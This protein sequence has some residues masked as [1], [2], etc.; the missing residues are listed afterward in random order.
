MQDFGGGHQAPD[1]DHDHEEVQQKR[2]IKERDG[3]CRLVDSYDG[4]I[5]V[6]DQKPT[7]ELGNYLG[8]GVAGVVYEGHRLRPMDEYPVRGGVLNETPLMIPP[9][10]KVT[11]KTSSFLCGDATAILDSEEPEKP[12][13]LTPPPKRA[14]SMA[15][16][17]FAIETA[18]G[19]KRDEHVIVVDQVDAPSRSMYAAR[20]ASIAGLTD[21]TV[22]IKIL[23]PVGFRIVPV[24]QIKT[25][26]VVRKGEALSKDIIQR[27][28]PMQEKHVWWLINPSSRNL[29]TLQKSSADKF[30][31]GTR[32]RGLRLS[33]VAAYVDP[34]TNNL[35]E[36][37]LT[38]CIEIWGHVPF[39]ASDQEFEDM[40]MAIERI[41]AG[42][43]ASPTCI[44]SGPPSRV[45]TDMSNTSA[46]E[47]TSPGSAPPL[48]PQRTYV[49]H[50][51][52][53]H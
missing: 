16:A 36:L 12:L 25:A 41:N 14:S 46:E 34:T 20:A 28:H 3:F 2:K 9:P 19:G 21:E 51:D 13:S 32:E 48:T 43:P 49:G 50:I 30:E 39:S 23:N 5:I 11:A 1:D 18:V 24:E 10:Q 44:G 35:R 52:L 29:R 6:V 15:G 26:V 42:Q 7:Y 40:M 22:A 53:V 45:G 17:D 47:T 38:R 8:G 37:P 33:L 31:R 4:Q 27:R